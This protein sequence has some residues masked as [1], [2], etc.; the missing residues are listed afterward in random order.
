MAHC[1]VVMVPRRGRDTVELRAAPAHEPLSSCAFEW[2]RAWRIHTTDWQ[3]PAP[4]QVAHLFGLMAAPGDALVVSVARFGLEIDPLAF[5]K[6]SLG[7]A[8]VAEA[9]RVGYHGLTVAVLELPS[10][11]PAWRV[12]TSGP[13]VHLLEARGVARRYLDRAAST[14]RS[15]SGFEPPAQP[16]VAASVGPLRFQRPAAWTA[17]SEA[18]P[19]GHHRAHFRHHTS[20]G[21][22]AAY[23]RIHA[24]D[25]R[26]HVGGLPADFEARN[27]QR[28][29]VPGL[30]L[31]A[32]VEDPGPQGPTRRR[33]GLY[34]KRSVE[35][36]HAVRQ[37][38]PMLVFAD[39]CF[40][41]DDRAPVRRLNG[42]RCFD[43][44]VSTLRLEG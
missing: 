10:P 28:L 17:Q 21:H 32:P 20:E 42:R 18:S 35:T 15:L 3:P 33:E 16:F 5:L 24:V 26:V 19:H 40:P 29:D 43:L 8:V 2:P 9:T 7:S 41:G 36:R 39:A 25:R 14:L 44:A 11:G 31:G 12:V 23:L 13:A 4:L 6:R 34:L 27:T 37:V 38:G 30:A 1:E 22:L